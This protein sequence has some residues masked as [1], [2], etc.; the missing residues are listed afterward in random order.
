MFKIILQCWYFQYGTLICQSLVTAAALMG[1]FPIIKV[2]SLQ[3]LEAST[4]TKNRSLRLVMAC[5]MM[6]LTMLI[7]IVATYGWG[8]SAR[9]VWDHEGICQALTPVGHQSAALGQVIVHC[10]TNDLQKKHNNMLWEVQYCIPEKWINP[11]AAKVCNQMY[12][13]ECLLKGQ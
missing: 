3:A 11:V 6:K 4:Y 1:V 8:S 13:P 2:R 10:L 7:D 9:G 12:P 5:K